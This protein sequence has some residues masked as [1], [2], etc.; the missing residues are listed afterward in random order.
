VVN[1][2][3]E[4]GRAA[5]N[6]HYYISTHITQAILWWIQGKIYRCFQQNS[7]FLRLK[8]NQQ[9]VET[10]SQLSSVPVCRIKIPRKIYTT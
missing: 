4:K 6:M 2:D 8:Y 5:K 3:E 10:T 9:K 7:D 1:T